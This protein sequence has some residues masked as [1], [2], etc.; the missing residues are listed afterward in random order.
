MEAEGRYRAL[1][2]YLPRERGTGS[3][4][5]VLQVEVY[6]VVSMNL[7]T[8]R[9]YPTKTGG[10]SHGRVRRKKDGGCPN[11]GRSRALAMTVM[12]NDGTTAMAV[13]ETSS[14]F[15]FVLPTLL[16]LPRFAFSVSFRREC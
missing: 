2:V 1:F 7:A 16:S 6:A 4:A 13:R 8:T 5:E 12:P 14:L 9:P 10:I 11:R 15:S 3:V